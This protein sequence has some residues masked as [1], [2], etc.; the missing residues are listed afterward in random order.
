MKEKE[1]PHT[2]R[3]LASYSSDLVQGV[4]LPLAAHR[5]GMMSLVEAEAWAKVEFAAEHGHC[6]TTT[7]VLHF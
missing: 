5:V 2:S 4:A 7:S 6:F 1:S 3:S